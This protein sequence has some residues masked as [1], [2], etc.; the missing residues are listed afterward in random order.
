MACFGRENPKLPFDSTP[1]HKFTARLRL[2]RPEGGLF[3]ALFLAQSQSSRAAL[4]VRPGTAGHAGCEKPVLPEAAK[5]RWTRWERP[6]RLGRREAK[7]GRPGSPPFLLMLWGGGRGLAR[8]A[9][10]LACPSK[11][12]QPALASRA[13]LG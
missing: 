10:R 6:S 4:A 8:K 7:Q 11:K 5:Y 13:N 2:S 12:G 1:K 9:K 3:L